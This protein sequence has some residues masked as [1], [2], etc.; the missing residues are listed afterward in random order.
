MTKR[1]VYVFSRTLTYI[2][3]KGVNMLQVRS[4]QTLGIWKNHRQYIL[5]VYYLWKNRTD[6]D[7]DNFRCVHQFKIKVSILQN[8]SNYSFAFR[9]DKELTDCVTSQF[10]LPCLVTCIALNSVIHYAKNI[11]IQLATYI[12]YSCIQ[13]MTLIKLLMTN[14]TTCISAI[15]NSSVQL[16]TYI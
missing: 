7:L 16:A 10:H 1:H 14:I 4:A 11:I 12:S 5:R 3:L 13:F 2:G 15:Y 9:C 6:C 8:D